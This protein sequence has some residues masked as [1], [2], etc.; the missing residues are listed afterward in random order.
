M[1]RIIG[2]WRCEAI[3]GAYPATAGGEPPMELGPPTNSTGRRL[4]NQE[5]MTQKIKNLDIPF[6]IR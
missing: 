6:E 4:I 2:R 5:E 1:C 3:T